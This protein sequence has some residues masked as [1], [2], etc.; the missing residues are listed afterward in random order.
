LISLSRPVKPRAS[1]T[2]LIA[3]SVPELTI[4]TFSMLGTASM[5]SSASRLSASVGA[6]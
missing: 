3:A 2:A 4:R 1:R 5:I 6:P